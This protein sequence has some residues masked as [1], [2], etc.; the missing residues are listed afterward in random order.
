MAPLGR[1]WG[2]RPT[3]DV[4]DA[5][6]APGTTQDAP[7]AAPWSAREEAA[8]L[9]GELTALVRRT[10]AAGG[11]LPVGAVPAVRS[12]E[13]VLRPLLEHVQH[14]GGSAEELLQLRSIV[15]EHLPE[16][17]D[18]Y[19]ALPEQYASTA[20]GTG[21]STPG[22]ELVSQLRLLVEGSEQLARAVYDSDAQQ[23]AIGRRFL[24]SK[25]RR[26]DLDL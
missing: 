26:S 3:Q 16:A 15:R 4:D 23:L 18:T 17:V 2:R 12:A 24:D 19:L 21:G 9:A 20:R 5:A 13:D 6:P 10:N 1:W 14:Q 25:F 22:D 7:A 11:R 8:A